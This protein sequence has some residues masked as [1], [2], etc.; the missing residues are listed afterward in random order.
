M[1]QT[2]VGS[3][4]EC[5]CQG[6][7]TRHATPVGLGKPL[8]IAVNGKSVLVA[9]KSIL[10]YVLADLTQVEIQVAAIGV[11]I[12]G[13]KER[14]HQPEL[15]VLHVVGVKVGVVHL[16]HYAAPALLGVEKV[17]LV[18]DVLCVKVIGAALAG[19]E[20]EVEGLY[21]VGLA[22]LKLAVGEQLG[23]GDFAHVGVGHLFG[24]VLQIAGDGA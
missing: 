23:H 6:V 5:V 10:K 12:V 17:A 8:V 20:R 18:V 3:V 24:I 11:G 1:Q 13:V 21:P 4:L 15:D 2:R 22:I 16:A 9:L 14:I 19:I 7:L